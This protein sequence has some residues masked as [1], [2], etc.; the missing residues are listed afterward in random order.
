MLKLHAV[1][2]EKAVYAVCQKM[3]EMKDLAF[4]SFEEHQVADALLKKALVT[5]SRDQWIARVKVLAELVEHHIEEEES[6]FLPELE[7]HLEGI[8]EKMVA[9]FLSLRQKS[10]R[11]FHD[12]NAGVLAQVS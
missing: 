10:Q 1:S 7:D 4:H 9:N 2:E 6:E 11:R 8:E 5:R 3:D 12:D